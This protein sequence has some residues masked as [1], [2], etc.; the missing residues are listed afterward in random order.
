M[1]ESDCALISLD[2]K[3]NKDTSKRADEMK[4]IV[5]GGCILVVAVVCAMQYRDYRKER[6]IAEKAAAEAQAK[7]AKVK[8]LR[9][10]ITA[11]LKDPSSAQ[12]Q[13][14]LLSSGQETLCG[15][16]NAKNS[17]GG[18]VGFKRYIANA[19]GFLIEGEGFKTWSMAHN[20]TPVPDY[21]ESG[22]RFSDGGQQVIFAKDIFKFLW[23][24]NCE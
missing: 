5:L 11:V 22:A 13:G 21:I 10:G 1:P 7:E 18:Y 20:K 24:S 6:D 19:H 12:W 15:E 2:N 23:T 16:V 4:K 9:Q 3:L 8:T 17:L 14:E